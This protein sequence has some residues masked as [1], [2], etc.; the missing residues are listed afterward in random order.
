[1]FVNEFI[2]HIE[3]ICN[4]SPKTCL[5]YKQDLTDFF[6][7]VDGREVTPNLISDY[8]MFKRDNGCSAVSVNRYI[9]AIRSYFDYCCRFSTGKAIFNASTPVQRF[10]LPAST[11]KGK[12]FTLSFSRQ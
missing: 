2:N 12:H 3:K 4:Y 1:M 9:S 6:K 7:F 11:H 10:S 8:V 5:C